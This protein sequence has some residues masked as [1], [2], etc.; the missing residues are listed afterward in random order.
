MALLTAVS[1]GGHADLLC[2]AA[3]GASPWNGMV[4]MYSLMGAFHSA[5]WLRLISSRRSFARRA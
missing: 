5:P 2:A 4:A 3:H 1:G